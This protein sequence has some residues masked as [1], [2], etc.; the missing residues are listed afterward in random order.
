MV[1][2]MRDLRICTFLSA[3]AALVI[4]VQASF[5]QVQPNLAGIVRD[6][7]TGKGLAGAS[8]SGIGMGWG[9][10]TDADGCFEF[11]NLLAGFYELKVSHIGYAELA[12][13]DVRIR[14]GET[15]FLSLNL[16]PIA[17]SLQP[18]TVFTSH[19]GAV[20]GPSATIIQGHELE[21]HGN[22][23]VAEVLKQVSGVIIYE[24]GGR[25]GRK[26][27]SI[28]GCRP[29]QVVVEVDGISMNA[30]SGG[31]V[32]LSQ[33]PTDQIERV[34]IIRGGGALSASSTTMGGL[35]RIVTRR[36]NFVQDSATMKIAAAGG[37]FGYA[38]GSA[39]MQI[40][41]SVPAVE[42]YLRRSQ[43]EGNFTYEERGSEKER[44]NNHYERWLGQVSGLWSLG[45]SLQWQMLLSADHR[46]RG[47]PGLI[48]QS[49][50]PEAS[51]K[52]EPMR[53]TSNLG[54]QRD[55]FSAELTNYYHRQERE[56]RS[57]REQYDPTEHQTYFHAPVW[58]TDEER[59][60]GGILTA[61]RKYGEKANWVR[62][63]SGGVH[64]RRD[65]YQGKDYLDNGLISNQS[66]GSVYRNTSGIQA[67]AHFCLP[68]R[69]RYLEWTGETRLDAVDQKALAGKTYASARG[70]V[71]LIPLAQQEFF[72]N[73]VVSG[74]FGSSYRLPSFVS[75]FLVESVFALGNK[76]LKPERS[77]DGDL[78]ILGEFRPEKAGWFHSWEGSANAFWNRVEDMIV[79][80][81]NF[82]G[83]YFPDNVAIGEIK[84][85]ELSTQI[86]LW[87]DRV[88]LKGHGTFQS[89]L[90]KTPDP[91]FYD[92]VLPL[93]PE[94]QG[95]ASVEWDPGAFVC[96]LELRTMGRRYTTDDNTDA[97]ST[98]QR[99][100]GPFTVFDTSLQWH[101]TLRFARMTW[102]GLVQNLAD[103]SYMIV[104][105]S[106]MPGRSYELQFSFER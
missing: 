5:G 78:G 76:N 52:E 88:I 65:E 47:S 37:S 34:E 15:T 82:R 106:P 61:S 1:S 66:L 100:L 8:V 51:L 45:K 95:G 44:T 46:E 70:R 33:F 14:E 9:T 18:V 11:Y 16:R 38:E 89:A 96:S 68:R 12:K 94:V 3:L 92:K 29:D 10:S 23:D 77:R 79:W 43:S 69:A 2:F 40:P 28:R 90:N 32:D 53:A 91:H 64:F 54:W 63:I 93:Q 73:V 6:A 25:G 72:W 74:S 13:P 41:L 7:Q 97:L 71:S 102:R 20:S 30:A 48:A 83:Q 26:T 31:A 81:R 21:S 22:A 56:Y 50:T 101:K 104:E 35:I 4:S 39:R 98:A 62:E 105:R 49:P 85:I 42:L 57:P 24:E 67:K 80:R 19:A 58:T 55:C 86:S 36:P 87:N 84:G 103:E 60:W 17:L 27:V 99:D 59:A 75:L